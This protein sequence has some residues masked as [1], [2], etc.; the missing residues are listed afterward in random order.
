MSVL[1]VVAHPDDEVLGCGAT[2]RGLASAGVPVRSCILSGA[3]AARRKRPGTPKLRSDT[4][5]A[6][7]VLGL[8]SPI[9]GDFPNI[10]L[11]TVPHL[12]LVQFIESAMRST[13]ATTLITHHPSDL[14]DDHL[15]TSRACQAAA[16]LC[17]REPGMPLLEQLLYMEVLSSTDWGFRQQAQFAPD[18][19]APIEDSWLDAKIDAL[20]CYEGVMRPA[21][22]PR[23][24]E[25]IRS[26]AL[27]RGAQCGAT[28]A[29]A[30]QSAFVRL[31]P[32]NF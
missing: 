17:Q 19:F 18:A 20:R 3:A 25:A 31:S 13:N 29:E 12:D 10:A 27:L 8:Q 26:L 11:N 16:R 5:E 4:E 21:P 2:A 28:H 24:E 32:E 1:I 22:H 15:H 14:N 9:I 23:R 30:F 7:R 6:S